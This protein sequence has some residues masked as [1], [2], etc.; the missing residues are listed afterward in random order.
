MTHPQP[1]SGGSGIFPAVTPSP[2]LLPDGEG[3]SPVGSSFVA[4]EPEEGPV[5]WVSGGDIIAWGRL[6]SSGYSEFVT[7]AVC[8]S[9][10]RNPV[11]LA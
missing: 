4:S 1:P 9:E 7:V 10:T 5:S 11:Q 6:P 3:G 8:G 2:Q